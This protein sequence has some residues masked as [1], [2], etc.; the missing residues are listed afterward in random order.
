MF[1][2][3]DF[4]GQEE[5]FEKYSKVKG[6]FLYLQFYD[7][8]LENNEKVNYKDIKSCIIYDKNLRDILYIYLGTFEEYFRAQMLEKYDLVSPYEYDSHSKLSR[9][10]QLAVHI[11]EVNGTHERS[12]LYSELNINF[13]EFIELIELRHLYNAETCMELNEI[14]KLRNNVMHHNIVV[15]GNARTHAELIAHRNRV[16]AR[17]NIL[18]KYLPQDYREN[19]LNTIRKIPCDVKEYRVIV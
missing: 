14:R 9:A 19:F 10:Q 2:K 6:K 8:F 12:E 5:D 11:G 13:G 15:L 17:I 7:I 3:L 16:S 4:N 18:A 1:E